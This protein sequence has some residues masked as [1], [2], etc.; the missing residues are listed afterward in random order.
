MRT[1]TLIIMCVMML[2]YGCSKNLV[3]EDLTPTSDNSTLEELVEAP[4]DENPYKEGWTDEQRG[5]WSANY[6]AMLAQNPNTRARF[7]PMSVYKISA[8]IV[9]TWAK[10]LSLTEFT[11]NVAKSNDPIVARQ[12]YDVTYQCTTFEVMRQNM[13]VQKDMDPKDAI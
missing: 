11:N 13:E 5:F 9:D 2:G 12:M 4:I 1:L 3:V 10:Q 6:W 8:C 7:L